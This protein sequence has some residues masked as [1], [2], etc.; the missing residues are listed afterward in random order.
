[1]TRRLLCPLLF[2]FAAC[3]AST[4]LPVDTAYVTP[5]PR[6]PNAP[7]VLAV[8]AHPD[9]DVAFAGL[10]YKN[11]THLG[12][13]ADVCVLTNGEGGFKYATLAESIYDLPLT[14]EAV[15]RRELPA[16]RRAEMVEGA[17]VMNVRRVMFLRQQDHRYTTDEFEILGEDATVWDVN[18]VRDT[19]AQILRAGDYDFLVTFF[20]SEGTHGHH[21]SAAL[22]ALQAVETL[23]AD[24]RPI[25][26][27]VRF[28]RSGEAASAPQGLADW[29]I[30]T[31]LADA[32]SFHFDRGQG[33]GHDDK[34]NYHIIAN[35]A[36]AAHRSQGTMQLFMGRG[37]DLENYVL[38]AHNGAGSVERA[39]AWFARLA[40]AQFETKSYGPSAGMTRR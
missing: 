10:M 37:S 23:P 9:D 40:E 31:P 30:T 36:I 25:T 4:P 35:W 6:D 24:E 39:R 3:A 38:Y 26:L 7:R 5:G 27:G 34:L 20:P 1:M 18:G 16:I 15:G 14:E 19:L 29:P 13:L 28:L 22:L 12:G 8:V 32:P 17:R 33:F 11:A 21:K 2:A